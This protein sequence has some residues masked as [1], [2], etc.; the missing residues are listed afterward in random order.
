MNNHCAEGAQLK[1][2]LTAAI[3]MTMDFPLPKE[4]NPSF[5]ERRDAHARV[6][7]TKC[8]IDL[9]LNCCSQCRR[10]LEVGRYTGDDA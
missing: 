1:R 8:A 9:H 5:V 6:I 3:A 4:D 2:E 7:N 10:S